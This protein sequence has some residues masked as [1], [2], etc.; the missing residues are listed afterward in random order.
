M[1]SV[2][3]MIPGNSSVGEEPRADLCREA[4]RPLGVSQRQITYRGL[5]DGPSVGVGVEQEHLIV[6]VIAT[7][8]TVEDDFLGWP[9]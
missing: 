9:H 5:Y 7:K 2:F 8:T 3:Q 4:Q 1:G 6:A